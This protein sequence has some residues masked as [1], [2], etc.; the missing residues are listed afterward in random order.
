MLAVQTADRSLIVG[1]G[2]LTAPSPDPFMPANTEQHI[3]AELDRV[4]EMPDRL[5]V[6][7]WTGTHVVADRPLIIDR[8]T[9]AVRLVMLT[10]G[11]GASLAFA[12][13]E[14]VVAGLF[15]SAA[16]QPQSGLLTSD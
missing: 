4:L 11:F 15:G 8:P 12:V 5:V 7:R 10:G 3:L 9:D 16:S 1:D 13:A 14:E 2:R 6:E